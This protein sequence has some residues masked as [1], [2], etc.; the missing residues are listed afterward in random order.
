VR[1]TDE[2]EDEDLS[3]F[4][5]D[6]KVRIDDIATGKY[7]KIDSGA[8][9]DFRE[10]TDVL[11]LVSSEV[12]GVTGDVINVIANNTAV[13]VTNGSD[14]TNGFSTV[15]LSTETTASTVTMLAGSNALN[16][17]GAKALTL[18]ATSTASTVTNNGVSATYKIDGTDDVKIAGSATATDTI[19][20]TIRAGV[21]LSDNTFSNVDVIKASAAASGADT[22]DNQDLIVNSSQVSGESIA[23]IG[24][25]GSDSG[26]EE[27]DDTLTVKANESSVNLG[28]LSVDTST[29]TGVTIDL[30]SV[31]SASVNITGSN[32][33]DSLSNQGSGAITVDG[34][35]GI[36]TLTT[37]S[38][39]DTVTGGEGADVIRTMHGSDTVHLAEST[40]AADVVKVDWASGELNT[41]TGFGV[42]SA[43]TA[44]QIEL[45]L[46]DAGATLSNLD[47]NADVSGAG[48]T[49]KFE[50][51]TAGTSFEL[52]TAADNTNVIVLDGDFA[53][54][55]TVASAISDGGA[56]ELK[57]GDTNALGAGDGY[58]IIY[59]NGADTHMAFAKTA[60]SIAASASGTFTVT[61]F[62]VLEG[63]AD[64]TTLVAANLDLI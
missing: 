28:E 4:D 37:G 24:T 17:S 7:I 27:A 43:S 30:T 9:I 34:K 35:G 48:D 3:K 23:V 33:K 50:T 45:V 52:A 42:G 40:A 1:I 6:I 14:A 57:V 29:I 39:N 47:D 20:V 46:A 64:A 8:T 54:A 61:D 18:A 60:S 2:A 22:A 25:L 58:L 5:N 63:V 13:A 15:N 49:I 56:T 62:V 31:A 19:D 12:A 26:T 36:D 32:A 44:D 41:V 53:D 10:N 51:V 55:A 21:D 38:G 59:D 16:I 11:D